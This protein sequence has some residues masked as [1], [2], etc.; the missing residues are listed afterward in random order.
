M[1]FPLDDG[2]IFIHSHSFMPELRLLEHEQSDDVP[3][4]LWVKDKL[5][6]LTT[7]AFGIKTD[8]KF[9]IK[10]LQELIEEHQIIVKSC[11]YDNHNAS[12]FISDLDFLG[13]DLIDIPQSA[14][15][16]N[17]A[18]VDFQLSVKAKQVKYNKKIN[19]LNGVL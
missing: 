9:I 17:D 7:G 8:Y 3:Y 16:L 5:L 11:G 2:T 14:K 18:T 10:Y 1:I 12:A 6:T 19:Y 4:R 15:S 13:C